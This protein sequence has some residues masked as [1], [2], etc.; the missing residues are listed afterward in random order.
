MN[1]KSQEEPPKKRTAGK[2]SHCGPVLTCYRQQVNLLLTY[3][4]FLGASVLQV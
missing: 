3:L 4:A 1:C 2:Q